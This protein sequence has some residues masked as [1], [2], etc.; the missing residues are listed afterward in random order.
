M[1]EKLKN[2][3]L[4]NG[5]ALAYMGDAVYEVAIREHLLNQGYTKPNELHNHATHYVSAKAQAALI[6]QMQEIEFLTE[7][8]VGIFK[9]GRNANSH[10]KAKNTDRKTYNMSSGFEAVIGFVYLMGNEERVEEII[11]WCIDQ[12][13]RDGE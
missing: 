6:E 5:L 4:L 13:E 10:T 9:R 7:E 2:P 3:N 8:E 1:S 11:T 12:V